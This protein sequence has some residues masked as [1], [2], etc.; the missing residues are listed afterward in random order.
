MRVYQFLGVY[1][2]I[3]SSISQKVQDI[4]QEKGKNHNI[5]K[6]W[7]DGFIQQ[8]NEFIKK[9]KA[10]PI[11]EKRGKVTTQEVQQSG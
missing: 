4:L 11:E 8:N 10:C 5:S 9:E 6:N 2:I 1:H 7:V 3:R